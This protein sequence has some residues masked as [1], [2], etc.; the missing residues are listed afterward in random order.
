MGHRLRRSRGAF[1]GAVML[2][3]TFTLVGVSTPPALASPTVWGLDATFGVNGERSDALAAPTQTD[4]GRLD[5]DML[6]NG[7]TALVSGN[8]LEA[9]TASGARDSAFNA[10]AAAALVPPFPIYGLPDE[11]EFQSSGKLIVANADV[12]VRLNLNGTKDS[13]FGAAGTL[14]EPGSVL[15]GFT[16]TQLSVDRQDRILISRRSPSSGFAVIRYTAN[17]VLDTS[18]GVGGV[19]TIAANIT[20]STP[21]TLSNSGPLI[22]GIFTDGSFLASFYTG[23]RVSRFSSSGSFDSTFG[24]AGELLLSTS[25]SI[26]AIGVVVDPPWDLV[27]RA[28]GNFVSSFYS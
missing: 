21:V 19:V 25:S 13:T 26:N 17:G 27:T 22:R 14:S 6:D 5:L 23:A 28:D 7:R 12:L 20:S 24:L 10:A 18:F 9:F 11:V 4:S 3:A 16:G 15:P 2:F 1:L 8:G